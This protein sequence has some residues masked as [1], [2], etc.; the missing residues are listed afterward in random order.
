VA[1]ALGHGFDALLRRALAKD[2]KDRFQSGGEFA[3]ALKKLRQQE[4]PRVSQSGTKADEIRLLLQKVG[5][6]STSIL[7]TVAQRTKSGA[8]GWLLR[9]R[10]LELKR[11][12]S[13]LNRNWKVGM[14]TGLVALS[15]FAVLRIIQARTSHRVATATPDSKPGSLPQ[16]A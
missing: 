14:A 11:R 5:Q 15:L 9:A 12:V 3:Q 4:A 16:P 2:P 13:E 6:A 7:L 10:N 1:P 8:R